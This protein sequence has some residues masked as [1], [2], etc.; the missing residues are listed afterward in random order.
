MNIHFDFNTSINQLKKEKTLD[1]DGLKN[2][3]N[4]LE[5]KIGDLLKEFKGLYESSH[6]VQ[7]RRKFDALKET[8]EDVKVFHQESLKLLDLSNEIDHLRNLIDKKKK[9]LDAIIKM[10]G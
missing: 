4:R 5:R 9:E 3:I 2:E 6:M 10:N 1:V 8:D 7:F